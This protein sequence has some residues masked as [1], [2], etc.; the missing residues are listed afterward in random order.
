MQTWVEQADRLSRWQRA[1]WYYLD[2]ACGPGFGRRHVTRYRVI[3]TR[4]EAS[5][6]RVMAAVAALE[7]RNL[8]RVTNR[9]AEHGG[10]EANEFLVMPANPRKK[11]LVDMVAAL[12]DQPPLQVLDYLSRY[13]ALL[14]SPGFD[15]ENALLIDVAK[16][17]G[18]EDGTQTPYCAPFLD[19]VR[20]V[21][22][23]RP[24]G[25]GLTW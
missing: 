14:R 7:D 2:D 1:V 6:R 9:K 12:I 10:Y 4:I 22:L 3:A 21:G 11:D 19:A 13:D 18:Y 5:K 15:W 20:E 16:R 23:Y 25:R 24:D 17:I 8:V